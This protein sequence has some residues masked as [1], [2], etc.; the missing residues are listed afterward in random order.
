M[1]SS[2]FPLK[3]RGASK[4]LESGRI[5]YGDSKALAHPRAENDEN[6]KTNSSA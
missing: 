4:F 1:V 6:G 5:R 3:T 2:P